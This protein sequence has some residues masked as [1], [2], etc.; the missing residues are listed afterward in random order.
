MLCSLLKMV[1]AYFV[2]TGLLSGSY[3]MDSKN[4]VVGVE[5]TYN[6]HHVSVINDLHYQGCF[7]HESKLTNL[8]HNVFKETSS[9]TDHYLIFDEDKNF[10]RVRQRYQVHLPKTLTNSIES[11][12]KHST[13]TSDKHSTHFIN[14]HSTQANAQLNSHQIKSNYNHKEASVMPSRRLVEVRR[15]SQDSSRIS[16]NPLRKSSIKLSSKKFRTVTNNPPDKRSKKLI[17]K[18]NSN[19]NAK[20]FKPGLR[21]NNNKNAVAKKQAVKQAKVTGTKK[22][23][24][25]STKVTGH[26]KQV[27]KQAKVTGYKKQAFRS[28]KVT[29]HKK[30]VTKQAKVTG[31]KKQAVRSSKVTGH[32]KQVTKQA[33]VTGAK[34][35]AVKSTKVTD[36]KKP[37]VKSTKVSGT[38][39]QAKIAFKKQAVRSS[40]V[41]GH[42]KPIVKSTKVTGHK[43]HAIEQSKIYE[44]NN[45]LTKKQNV[46]NAINRLRNATTL[47]A[48]ANHNKLVLPAK[49]HSKT[50]S[51][52]AT[53]PVSSVKTVTNHP[54]HPVHPV[55]KPV[56][57]NQSA[58]THSQKIRQVN[59][60]GLVS[61]IIPAQVLDNRGKNLEKALAYQK[62]LTHL[63]DQANSDKQSHPNKSTRSSKWKEHVDES[64]H[65]DLEH[66][67][68]HDRHIDHKHPS[69]N[70]MKNKIKEWWHDDEE[71]DADDIQR[72]KHMLHIIK[73]HPHM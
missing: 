56:K 70:Y 13:Q 53:R 1:K 11:T 8:T 27:T 6:D 60:L 49:K 54:V 48:T 72:M 61:P 25:R 26:K 28:S 29:G 51:S 7:M 9:N 73:K 50:N 22:P 10:D 62:K 65:D 45:H 5:M 44:F 37:V 17:G 46:K 63:N 64:L 59:P 20:S 42:K 67:L 58:Q 66:Y 24:V 55:N 35:Q 32:K 43:N 31:Y 41:T 16:S 68:N 39:K 30:Q 69:I 34:K 3:Y 33:K 52:K 38:K 57:P 2:L 71:D 21:T 18:P 15:S 19:P 14:K 4:N 36:N 12:D 23:V 40:K 47:I